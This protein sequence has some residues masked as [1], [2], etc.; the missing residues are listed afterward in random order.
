MNV[1]SASEQGGTAGSSSSVSSQIARTAGQASSGTR[2]VGR[3]STRRG[4]TLLEMIISTGA[5]TV[6]LG[7]LM[8][9]IVVAN[10]AWSPDLKPAI[11][12]E[13]S[14]L[15]RQLG[16]DLKSALYFTERTSTA[17]TFAVPDRNSD[18]QPEILRY[19]WSGTDGDPLTVSL[20]GG[21]AQVVVADVQTFNM[22]YLLRTVTAPVIPVSGEQAKTVLFIT[23]T[24]NVQVD[25]ADRD[26]LATGEKERID[27]IELWGFDVAVM[28]GDASDA[29]WTSQLEVAA[30]VYVPGTVTSDDVTKRL[31]EAIQGV[32]YERALPGVDCGYVSNLTEENESK[33]DLENS[34]HYITSEVP[35]GVI[36]VLTAGRLLQMWTGGFSPDVQILARGDKNPYDASLAIMEAQSRTLQGGVSPGRRV[37]LPWGEDPATFGLLTDAALS[38]TQRSI[39]WAAGL[40]D[41]VARRRVLY[42]VDNA[43]SFVQRDFDRKIMFEAAGFEVRLL[44]QTT[45]PTQLLNEISQCDAVYLAVGTSPGLLLSSINN[46]SQGV[47][48][49]SPEWVTSL[50]FSDNVSSAELSTLNVA[51]GSHSIAAGFSGSSVSITRSLTKAAVPGGNIATGTSTIFSLVSGSGKK[52]TSTPVVVSIDEGG[53]LA[54]KSSATGRRTLVPFVYVLRSDL[55]ADGYR[56]MQ[57][58][59]DWTASQPE[60]AAVK[61][62]GSTSLERFIQSFAL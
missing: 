42:L 5:A 62:S 26:A 57:Q 31:Y 32:V 6:L 24:S 56:L 16:I 49:E 12:T 18:G 38:I 7:G 40:D 1:N 29:D 46:V 43:T 34:N 19:S 39:M 36:S 44:D 28:S 22:D 61:S 21:A 23:S 13:T 4:Y 33:I 30:A 53:Q 9:T 17:A 2:H 14:G 52:A 37:L 54:D 3:H 51:D 10:R 20:N 41:G 25:S 59:M 47:M 11:K 50:G 27:A 55:T 35:A 58:A 8:S 15:T 45:E 60:A 48:T